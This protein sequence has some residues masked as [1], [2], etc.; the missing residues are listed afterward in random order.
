MSKREPLAT[1]VLWAVFTEPVRL[2]WLVRRMTVLADDERTSPVIRLASSDKL[3]TSIVFP[4]SAAPLFKATS[5]MAPLLARTS[6]CRL[7]ASMLTLA[8]VS[9]PGPSS[10]RPISTRVPLAADNVEPLRI[11]MRASIAGALRLLT[12][13]ALPVC[14]VRLE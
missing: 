7:L 8:W 13:I 12:T 6:P 5:A 10:G 9:V 4:V 1:S 11:S 2:A 3:V 14:E